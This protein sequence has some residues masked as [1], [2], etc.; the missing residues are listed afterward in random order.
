MGSMKV[1]LATISAMVTTVPWGIKASVVVAFCLTLTDTLTG[2]W[3]AGRDK[4]F[5]SRTVRDM[6]AA[7]A[8]QF[9]IICTM[10]AGASLIIQE[11]HAFGAAIGIIVGIEAASNLENLTKLE[12]NGGA[13]LGPFRPAIMRLSKYFA[14]DEPPRDTQEGK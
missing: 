11:W 6:L 8:L 13:P 9:L 10:G 4:R 2:I 7:K 3:L 12:H 14:V 5:R 1:V